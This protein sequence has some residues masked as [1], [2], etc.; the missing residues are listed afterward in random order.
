MSLENSRKLIHDIA[1]Q[2]EADDY[3]EGL[4]KDPAM[5]G[6]ME[7]AAEQSE[8]LKQPG[9]WNADTQKWEAQPSR[10]DELMKDIGTI[11]P[12]PPQPSQETE[13]ER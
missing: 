1:A 4:L 2:R 7:R 10:W 5:R 11:A 12:E 13:L 3:I 8:A 9:V 6:D